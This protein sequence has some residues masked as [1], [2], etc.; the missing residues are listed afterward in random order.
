[1]SGQR[2]TG[3]NAGQ[4]ASEIVFADCARSA[5]PSGVAVVASIAS[6]HEPSLMP[7]GRTEFRG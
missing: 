4:A 1:M 2:R 3:G 6:P 7:V 5:K